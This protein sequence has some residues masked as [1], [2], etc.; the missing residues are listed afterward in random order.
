MI[1]ER[2][3]G[4]KKITDDQGCPESLA[5]M[6]GSDQQFIDGTKI[7]R[8]VVGVVRV[9]EVGQPE[10][11]RGR[12]MTKLKNPTLQKGVMFV[13][14]VNCLKLQ[15]IWQRWLRHRNASV[16]KKGKPLNLIRITTRSIGNCACQLT[17]ASE[18]EKISQPVSK[19][20]RFQ[21]KG[22]SHKSAKHSRVLSQIKIDSVRSC[23]FSS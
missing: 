7:T 4:I 9:E 18:K 20:F 21:N 16:D 17:L 2:D 1:S 5:K 10:V 8:F 14:S 3:Q 13:G 12:E 23:E 6:Q 22:I 15:R 11:K 19:P